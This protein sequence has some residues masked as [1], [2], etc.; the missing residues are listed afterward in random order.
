M[1]IGL[2]AANYWGTVVCLVGACLFGQ[3]DNS[4]E[5]PNRPLVVSAGDD[6]TVMLNEVA[7]CA[8][9]A[10]EEGVS[11]TTFT[12]SWRQTSGPEP[13][14]IL[15]PSTQIT[16][17]KFN[18]TG[19]YQLSLTVSDGVISKSDAVVFTV[20]D[21]VPFKALKPVAGDR[22]VIGNS[23]T[24]QWRIVTPLTQTMID[25][26][27]DKGKSWTILSNP[28][29]LNDTMWVWRVDVGLQPHD[30]CLIKIRDYNNFANFALSGYFSL[31]H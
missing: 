18:R 4:V 7:Y 21:S 10:T 6:D 30:S 25:L 19:D 15:S 17:V 28:S 26:S 29:V 23:F 20:I 22:I 5:V 31:V 16:R 27:V 9:S 3:C 14:Q 12:F 13:A 1:K 11:D 24:I 2:G 8:G